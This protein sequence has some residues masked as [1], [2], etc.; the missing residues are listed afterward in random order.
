MSVP[1]HA[2]QRRRLALALMLALAAPACGDGLPSELASAQPASVRLNIDAVLLLVGE[3]TTIIATL[4]DRN[5]QPIPNPPEAYRVTW[6]TSDE[7][8]ASV[9]NGVIHAVGH[10]HATVTAA[11][12]SLPAAAVDIEVV[13]PGT[14]LDRY[15]A[16]ALGRLGATRS[17]GWAIN[18]A[19][20][21]AGWSDVS[22]GRAFRWS[23]ADGM[24]A[25][26]G[27]SSSRGINS[28]GAIVGFFNHSSGFSAYVFQNGVRT[29]LQAIEAGT[30]SDAYRINDD[31]TVVGRSTAAHAVVWRRG[32]DGSYDAPLRLG[33]RN[34]NESPVI[35]GR[36]DI[37]FTAFSASFTGLNEPV[38]WRIQPDGSY[39]DA[40]LLGRP[41][42]GSHFVRDINDAGL[43]VGFRWTGTIEMA[44]LWHPADYSAPIDLGV[45]E[46]WGINNHGWIVGG[47]GGNLPSFGGVPR[48]PALWLVDASRSVHGPY[49]I[50]TPAGFDYGAARAI[51]D[52]G[53]ITGSAWGP[54]EVMATLWRP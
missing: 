48:R 40:L 26:P 10:G 36:G 25:L 24:T 33:Y 23:A 35:N 47:T 21:V 20:V 52:H 31:G 29:D 22:G 43:I 46:A 2:P 42:G 32:A 9:A 53:W 41:S 34:S 51:N 14:V 16:I 12:A 45:G 39:G 49:D 6:S 37:A 1:Q 54:G 28:A 8:V 5:G 27:I 4:H 15:E 17:N 30:N 18:D 11:A 19:G 50:G 13:S 3:D 7:D 38:L 44:V